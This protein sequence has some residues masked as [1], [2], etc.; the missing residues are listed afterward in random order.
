MREKLFF[1]VKKRSKMWIK[2]SL[3]FFRKFCPRC[4]I[5]LAKKRAKTPIKKI[6]RR[7]LNELQASK[8]F[9]A[10]VD[11]RGGAGG[12]LKIGNSLF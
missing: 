9:W 2:T 1:R 6:L 7:I 10:L 11:L 5:E 4:P 12:P 8:V 3:D